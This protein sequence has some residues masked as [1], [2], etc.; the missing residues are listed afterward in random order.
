MGISLVFCFSL[1][2]PPFTKVR[3]SDSLPSCSSNPTSSVPIWETTIVFGRKSLT[4]TKTSFSSKG[5][6]RQIF[7]SRNLLSSC[8]RGTSQNRRRA[9]SLCMTILPLLAKE[10]HY[11]IC[12]C[13]ARILPPLC[14]PRPEQSARHRPEKHLQAALCLPLH[15]RANWKYG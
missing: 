4:V 7:S 11:T 1:C 12:K 15:V 8:L 14:F 2:N 9:Y 10:D 5:G 13:R 6:C 3:C